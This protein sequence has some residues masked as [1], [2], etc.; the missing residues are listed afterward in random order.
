MVMVHQDSRI[1]AVNNYYQEFSFCHSLS[2]YSVRE[3][4]TYLKETAMYL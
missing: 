4:N 3:Q 2:N 1:S